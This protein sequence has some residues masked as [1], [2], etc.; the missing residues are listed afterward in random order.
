MSL[1]L[2]TFLVGLLI[3]GVLLLRKSSWWKLACLLWV[4]VLSG[5]QL[6]ERGLQK[7]IDL[8]GGTTLVYRV[9]IPDG[10]I[11]AEV[12]DQAIRVLSQRVDP[13]GTRNLI[14]Q[15]AAGGRLQ[16]SMAAPKPEV[17]EKREAW[18]VARDAACGD[19][20]S[21]A[22]VEAAVTAADAPAALAT[23]AGD[24]ADLQAALQV[25]GEA[26][27]GQD[28]PRGAWVQARKAWQARRS[29]VQTRLE[30]ARERLRE[31]QA[32]EAAS[33]AD[34]QASVELGAQ[35]VAELQA[36]V[37]QLVAALSGTDEP[38]F[39]AERQAQRDYAA[40]RQAWRGALQAT[41]DLGLD[42]R[43][44]ERTVHLSDQEMSDPETGARYSPRSRE[45]D[46]LTANWP[47]RADA[48]RAAALAWKDYEQV[49][50]PLET[51]EDLDR[52]IRG[53]GVLEF[54]FAPSMGESE[55]TDL[56]TWQDL[57]F[58]RGPNAL[59][60]EP[61]AWYPIDSLVQHFNGDETLIEDVQAIL[62]QSHTT[63]PEVLA[64]LTAQLRAML[65][66]RM[67]YAAR[68]GELLALLGNQAGRN[69]IM[70]EEQ[71]ALA[72][73]YPTYDQSYQPAVG[74]TLDGAG[75]NLM[76]RFTEKYRQRNM[77][78]LLDGRLL[79]APTL[80]AVLSSEAQITGGSGGFSPQELDYLVRT[81]KGGSLEGSIEGDPLSV[82]EVGPSLGQD[83]LA[84]GLEASILALIVVAVFMAIYYFIGGFIANFALCANLVVILG[85]LSMAGA[86]FT[87]SG[88]AGLVLTIGMAVDANV[89]IFER[90][91]EE[92]NALI[93]TGH[94]L[95]LKRSVD[96]GYRASLS[97]I[98]DANITTLL[99]AWVLGGGQPFNMVPSPSDLRGFAT[100]LGIGVIATLFTS[101]FGSKV[102]VD[103]WCRFHPNARMMHMLPTKVPAI[104]R[105]LHPKIAWVKFGRMAL[106]FSLILVV[107][108][109]VLVVKQGKDLYDIEFRSGAQAT[110]A[111]RDGSAVDLPAARERISTGIERVLALQAGAQPQDALD[112]A[113]LAV[114][115]EAEAHGADFNELSAAGLVA[116]EPEEGATGAR[117]TLKSLLTQNDIDGDG[118][119]DPDT[120]VLTHF[121]R[122]AFGEDLRVEPSIGWAGAQQGDFDK[123]AFGQYARPIDQ[124]SL[125]AVLGR[126]L[127]AG[128]SDNAGAFMGGV[129]ILLEDLNPQIDPE[130]LE[131]RLSRMRNQPPFDEYGARQM[132]V[133]DLGGGDV[134]VLVTDEVTSY[135]EAPESFTVARGLARSEWEMVQAALAR[136]SVFDSVTVFSSQVSGTMA[137][138][139]LQAMILALLGVVGYIWMRFSRFRYGMAAILAL[140]HDVSLALGVVALVSML[141]LPFVGDVRIGLTVVAAL[142]TIVGYSLND[143]IVVFDRIREQRG[144]L[145]RALPEHIDAA[146]NGTVSRTAL[147][148]MTTL[149]SIVLLL[150]LGGEGVRAFAFVMLIGIVVGTWS[151]I[152]VAAPVLMLGRGGGLNLEEEHGDGR[153]ITEVPS[154]PGEPV[155]T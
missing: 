75:A 90:I 150:V 130:T 117:F 93:K 140:I 23:L 96:E 6:Y 26:W 88:I 46:E 36:Q 116:V 97:T 19:V 87:M 38:L 16:V 127:P 115:D 81:M 32:K 24:N 141:D 64:E 114:A 61:F 1:P 13:N 14:W 128:E 105:A 8:A 151:S 20:L 152:A 80:Q 48:I 137:M 51:W 98:L 119:R 76:R 22:D 7:G 11:E 73:V 120:V 103:L 109:W 129:A 56:A 108:S 60:A 92:Q 147:T 135:T 63:D 148:S 139:A 70:R 33:T 149:L 68:D 18:E 35:S 145:K 66:G 58:E 143:T 144:R 104:E 34:D 86:T 49:R 15:R 155:G 138:G 121:L 111:M 78:V 27:Q 57:L 74:F 85:V 55:V 110:F 69:A 5:V 154:A 47:Q 142:L 44:L 12:I 132:R 72:S 131:T 84:K 45:I 9:Q 82:M 3:T 71:W 107:A 52:L 50:G 112:Q 79:T 126:A 94:A 122:A 30:A 146:I 99:T 54:R 89:L 133:V 101:L 2:I 123:M 83:N 31:A 67:I 118:H 21:S 10:S 42:A 106:P 134:A 91:R 29:D 59:S 113:L 102:L 100:V 95:S 125:Q 153:A 39:E 62:D 43:R 17:A 41:L 25:A 65:G 136:E 53:S 124:A 77:A 40:A 37:D 28:A 4:V